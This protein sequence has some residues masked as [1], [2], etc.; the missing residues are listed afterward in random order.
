MKQE[1]LAL[2]VICWQPNAIAS[3]TT[4]D[5]LCSSVFLMSLFLCSCIPVLFGHDMPLIYSSHSSI[6]RDVRNH[7]CTHSHVTQS[8]SECIQPD[9]DHILVCFNAVCK[10]SSFSVSKANTLGRLTKRYDW[11]VQARRNTPKHIL[12]WD[13]FGIIN[14]HDQHCIFI[15]LLGRY[16]RR[17]IRN[18]IIQHY[19]FFEFLVATC[20]TLAQNKVR[21]RAKLWNKDFFPYIQVY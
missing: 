11:P 20:A 6:S 21:S 4:V 19:K 9:F 10:V 8:H 14:C 5:N 15:L 18:L 2:V 13:R 17:C 16:R 12:L 1:K 7:L 3:G